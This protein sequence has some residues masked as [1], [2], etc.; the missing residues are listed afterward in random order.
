MAMNM[1]YA[2]TNLR[3]NR[4][5]R[6]RKSAATRAA[7]ALYAEKGLV[8]VEPTLALVFAR[9]NGRCYLCGETCSPLGAAHADCKRP[10]IDHVM[11]LSAGG[12]HA[13]A[14]CR[15]A[16]FRCNRHKSTSIIAEMIENLKELE[17]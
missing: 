5:Y 10:T 4:E 13:M 6:R 16:C 14:N 2:E 1:A 15:L 7:R 17:A 3:S 8:Y 9:D 11:P 12:L